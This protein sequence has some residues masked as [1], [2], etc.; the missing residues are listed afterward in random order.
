MSHCCEAPKPMLSNYLCTTQVLRGTFWQIWKIQTELYSQNSNE[1]KYGAF[2]LKN[3]VSVPLQSLLVQL[4]GRGASPYH[5]SSYF[6]PAKNQF[7]MLVLNDS[8]QPKYIWYLQQKMSYFLLL[9][10][11]KFEWWLLVQAKYRCCI[12]MRQ[13]SK[14]VRLSTCVVQK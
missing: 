13:I 5:L 6:V 11:K 9:F 12:W 2:Y 10:Y 3:E 4:S 8:C 1:S 7:N 14:K